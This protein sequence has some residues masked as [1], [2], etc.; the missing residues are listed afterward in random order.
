MKPDFEEVDEA[1]LMQFKKKLAKLRT[2]QGRGTELISLYLPEDVDRS[3]VMGQIT[4]ETSQSSNIKSP[5]TRK[6]GNV[7][8]VGNGGEKD[9]W[10]EATCT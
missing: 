1:E 5:T 6:N 4:E 3:S 7:T 10:Q 8:L 9:D 2:Y